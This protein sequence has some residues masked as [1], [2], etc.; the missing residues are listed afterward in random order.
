MKRSPPPP[1]PP[2]QPSPSS[3]PACSPSP[4]S[5]SSSD[6]SSI[7]IPRKRARTQS[8]KVKAAPKRAKKDATRSRKEPDASANGA[9]AAGKRSSIYRGVTRY[10]SCVCSLD[11]FRS[12]RLWIDKS[13]A[14]C[15]WLIKSLW[16]CWFP[17]LAFMSK[18]CS[19]FW[20]PDLS[21]SQLSMIPIEFLN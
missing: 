3:S 4:Y 12:Q 9:A 6:A 2:P 21:E 10:G 18:V 7:V 1:P 19:F 16:I 20:A 5:P 13:I 17:T 14:H 8:A 15:R 11:W